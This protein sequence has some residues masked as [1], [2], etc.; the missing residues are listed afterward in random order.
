MQVR[1]INLK[2]L[3]QGE[4]QFRV[5]LWQ[6]QYT[7]RIA[8]HRLLWRD[9]LEQYARAADGV[10]A[11]Q[12]GHFLGSVVLSPLPYAASDV[13]SYLIVDGQQRL[14]T[15]MLLLC[16][17]RD[18]AAKTDPRATERYDELYL[19][20]KFQQGEARFGSSRPRRTACRSL[21]ASR[22]AAMREGRTRS[23][24][25]TGSSA[26]MSSCSAPMMSR[27]TCTAWR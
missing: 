10:V 17:I 1:E 20:N 7:W 3:V 4:K 16:A 5:P 22:A 8:D 15:L 12:S 24:R 19:I 25:R 21:P 9:I 26:A 18:A 13:A 2:Q 14:T 11:N 6:R 23:A 27:L